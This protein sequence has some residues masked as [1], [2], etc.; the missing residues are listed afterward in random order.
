M[1]AELEGVTV[2]DPRG[3]DVEVI[4]HGIERI[5]IVECVY[6]DRLLKQRNRM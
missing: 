3:E 1:R 2:P 5:L 6:I 4:D